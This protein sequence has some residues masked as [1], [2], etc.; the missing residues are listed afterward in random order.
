MVQDRFYATGKRKNAIARVWLTPGTGKVIVNK[1]ATT[2]YFGKI[3][4]EHLIEK[5]FKTTDTFEK[6]DVIATLKGGGKSAQVDALAHGISRALLETDPENR[7]PL[8][9]AGLLRRDQR[10]KE[11][12]K[13]GQKG[14]R[15]KF[16]FSKR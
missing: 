6:Y 15:A 8:K 9:Q 4:K 2:E 12:K 10:V 5:P 11:R 3:F 16:Q 14:A 7:T 13:Y 1:M